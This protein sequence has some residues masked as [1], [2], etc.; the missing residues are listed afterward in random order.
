MFTQSLRYALPLAAMF[1]ATFAAAPAA[2]H[3]D[4]PVAR[5]SYADLNLAKEAGVK[6]LYARV[7]RAARSVCHSQ[8]SSSRQLRTAAELCIDTAIQRAVDE[9]DVAALTAHDLQHRGVR[10]L[11]AR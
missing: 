5:V 2:A 8:Y 7:E 9:V 11:S 6:T 1:A 10:R 3:Q 4:V